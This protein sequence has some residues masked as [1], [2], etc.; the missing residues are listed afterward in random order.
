MSELV[1][2]G[3]KITATGWNRMVRASKAAQVGYGGENVRITRTPHGTLINAKHTVGWNHPFRVISG[4]NNC[5]VNPGL[6]ND[7]MPTIHTTAGLGG[8]GG[9]IKLNASPQPYLFF[10]SNFNSRGEGYIAL[11]LTFDDKWQKITK[12][13]VIQCANINRL[14]T[15]VVD[16]PQFY[17]GFPGLPG[18]KSRYPI[19]KLKLESTG[20]ISV[21]QVAMFNLNHKSRPGVGVGS[22]RHFYWPA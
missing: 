9:D 18:F 10:N 3:D 14:D 6:V 13:E 19:A 4:R 7:I 20:G 22:V 12:C 21:F 8:G 5:I 15:E 11:E 17:Y 16:M 1:R 2:P